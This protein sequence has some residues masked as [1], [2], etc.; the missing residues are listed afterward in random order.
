MG[1]DAILS[2]QSFVEVQIPMCL[3]FSAPGYLRYKGDIKR[4][5]RSLSALMCSLSESM[6]AM[7][8][9]LRACAL[10]LML[11][12]DPK[13][14]V[15]WQISGKNGKP[16]AIESRNQFACQPLAFVGCI[17][18]WMSRR[19]SDLS[20]KLNGIIDNTAL[21]SLGCGRT[22]MPNAAPVLIDLRPSAEFARCHVH[23]SY[24]LPLDLL[25][26]RLYELPPMGEWQLQM[27]GSRE[28]LDSAQA[29]LSP[30]GWQATEV[31]IDDE[32]NWFDHYPVHVGVEQNLTSPY[33]PNSFLAAALE[34]IDLGDAA[35]ASEG[36]AVDLGCGSGRDAVH[37]AAA[38]EARAPRWT[39]VGLDNHKG[40]LERG[41]NLSKLTGTGCRR[42]QFEVADLRKAGLEAMLENRSAPLRFV[43]GCRWLDVPLLA[44]I[45]Q[46]LA[47]GGIV[48]WST[49]L[50][51]PDGSEPLAPPYKRS[52]RLSSG[53]MRQL[54]GEDAGMEVLY[55][56]EGELLT[57]S[58]WV[59]AQFFC[60]R[61]RA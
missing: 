35:R 53:Q 43:H 5:Q 58:E 29:L 37:I 49:F 19:C 24:S 16:V 38:L 14:Q 1:S 25:H 57:R 4:S 50:D 45:P 23:G 21:C 33:R 51:P 30:K 47:P 18:P 13:T 12:S 9:A 10:L 22:F 40:A 44:K 2:R 6:T 32:P 17:T 8:D 56:G 54:L 60:A 48:V 3:F 46:L 42:L 59:T 52:R 15:G 36:L 41:R 55:D 39:V 20:M 28:Q 27:L 26:E 31:D 7:S 61:K 34:A 11:L